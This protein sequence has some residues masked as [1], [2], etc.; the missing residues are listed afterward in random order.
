MIVMERNIVHRAVAFL[1]H[2]QIPVRIVVQEGRTGHTRNC[3]DG[4]IHP[5]HRLAGLMRQHTVAPGIFFPGSDL[6]GTVHLVAQAPGLHTVGFH[7]AVLFPQVGP[8]GTA[9]KVGIF[10]TVCRVLQRARSQ[11][12]GVN[13]FRSGLLRPLQ[14]FVVSHVVWDVL[15][16][17]HI[18]VGLPLVQGPDGVLPL[19][20]GNEV[21]AR[22]AHRGQAAFFQRLIK[23]PAQA[24]FIRRRMFRVKHAPVNHGADRLQE[25][26]EQP[27]GNL[28]DPEIRM[29]GHRCFLHL[30]ILPSY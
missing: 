13:R 11:V 12:H 23:I 5:L 26:A 10:H 15:E 20:A 18:Q 24:L 25:R 14:V 22:Q 1:Q 27:S 4:R 17:R 6:P 21:A 16:P 28:A 29:D 3:L 9:F 8:V 2:R 19:P 30:D 7:M